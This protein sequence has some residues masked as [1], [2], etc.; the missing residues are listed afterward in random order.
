[1]LHQ[2]TAKLLRQVDALMLFLLFKNNFCLT[3]SYCTLKVKVDKISKFF[4][5]RC[6]RANLIVFLGMTKNRYYFKIHFLK[7]Q[8]I[9]KSICSGKKCYLRLP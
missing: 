5:S 6:L 1:M 8:G 2:E 3:L 4:Q 7:S 9:P